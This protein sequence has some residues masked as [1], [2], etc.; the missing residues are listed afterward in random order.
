MALTKEMDQLLPLSITNNWVGFRKQKVGDRMRKIPIDPATGKGAKANDPN[1]WNTIRAACEA[2][3]RY[4]LDGIGIQLGQLY[5]ADLGG[6]IL[7]GV[8]L[9]HVIENGQLHPIAR[10]IVSSLDCYTEYS[11]SGTGL[12]MLCFAAPDTVK[13]MTITKNKSIG[14]EMY[15]RDRYFTVTGNIYGIPKYVVQRDAAIRELY[16]KHLK[17]LE[18]DSASAHVSP[19]TVA[20]PA[21]TKWQQYIDDNLTDMLQAIDPSETKTWSA[22]GICLKS[23]GYDVT[24]FDEWSKGG[25]YGGRQQIY[26]WWR[27]WKRLDPDA[28]KKLYSMAKLAGWIPPREGMPQKERNTGSSLEWDSVIGAREGRQDGLQMKTDKYTQMATQGQDGPTAAHREGV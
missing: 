13:D 12:H 18:K 23:L 10:E 27:F 4:G 8:D 7:V 24:I 19:S 25:N 1:T 15:S 22:V 20:M 16:E 26:R 28:G 21:D 6:V 11:P 9:D 17:P 2:Q 3:E 14:L 5:G